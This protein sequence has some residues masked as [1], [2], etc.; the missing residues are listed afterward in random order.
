MVEVDVVLELTGGE[1]VLEVEVGEL[2]VIGVDFV[3]SAFFATE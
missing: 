1:G 3:A 2:D